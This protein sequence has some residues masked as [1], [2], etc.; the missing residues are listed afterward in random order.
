MILAGD[1][2]GT[3]T[4]L[5][6][7]D[8][9]SGNL[10]PARE[11]TYPSR[12][13]GSLE[14]ILAKFLAGDPRP[15]VRAACFG[16]AGPIVEG[17][18]RLT[19]LPWQLEEASLAR[20]I[21]A[22]HVKLLNDLQ[23]AALGMLHLR[24]EELVDLNPEAREQEGNAAV[25]AA[26][27]GLGE[28]ILYWDGTRHHPVACEGGHVEFAPRT[29][30]EI[31][32]LRYLHRK[33][34]GRVSYERVISGPGIHNI[35]QFLRDTRYAPED[36]GTAG[37]IAGGDP[38]AAISEAALSGEDPLSVAAMDLFVSAYGAEAGN[39]ALKCVALGG[40]F[41][42]GGIAPKIL[43]ALRTGAF[44]RSFVDKGRYREFMRAIPVRVALDPRAPLLGAAHHAL[45]L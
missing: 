12:E 7:F 32:L 43:P 44:L 2:G 40:V 41:V 31:E 14:E 16:V 35:Y 29:E 18:T 4:T 27:T 9:G 13:H 25:I 21:G 8:E 30:R 23:A 6:L 42:G 5:A 26:G 20:A 45:G 37:K 39:I 15:A 36:P 10:R 34:G 11:A 38:S 1:V 24:P 28:A 19:N 33:L 17:R 22:P 3:H